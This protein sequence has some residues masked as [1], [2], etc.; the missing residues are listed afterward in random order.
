MN[1]IRVGRKLL[2]YHTWD[3]ELALLRLK[4]QLDLQFFVIQSN[5]IFVCKTFKKTF[6]LF[7][8]RCGIVIKKTEVVMQTRFGHQCIQCN[9]KKV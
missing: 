7:A 3:E 2:E 6:A 1:K 5:P 9:Y 4:L 8:K